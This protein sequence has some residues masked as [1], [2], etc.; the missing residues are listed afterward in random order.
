MWRGS[1][2]NFSM[3]MRS[4]PKEL[5]LGFERSKAFARLGV[6]PGDA[7]A[8]AAAAGRGLD[9]HRIADLAADLHRLFR[10]RRSGPCGRARSRRRLPRR[11]SSLVILSPIASMALAAGR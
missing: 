2:T 10:H 5:G 11:S 8:L 7:H 9:H 6:V 4:S 3:K 1:V